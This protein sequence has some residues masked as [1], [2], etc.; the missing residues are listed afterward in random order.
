MDK[1]QKLPPESEKTSADDK[2]LQRF[3]GTINSFVESHDDIQQILQASQSWAD[4]EVERLEKAKTWAYRIAGGAVLF[5]CGALWVAHEAIQTAMVPPPPP[6]VLVMNETTGAINPLMSLTEVKVKYEDALLRRALNTFSICRER[7]IRDMAE[8]D[9]FCAASFMSPQLQSQW[10]KYW[11]TENPNGPLTVYGNRASVKVQIESISPRQNSQGIVDTAQ[12][13]FTRTVT[14]NGTPT[15]T[16]WVADVS[17][18][19]VN[20][21]KEEAQRRVNDIGLQITQYNTNQVLSAASP[22]ARNQAPAPVTAA[23]RQGLTAP[24]YSPNQ[25][26]D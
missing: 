15:V 14:E 19:M 12:I 1:R 13:Y 11:D 6:Q 18:K 7:Y 9:Y 26:R 20:L 16:H 3:L 24:A 22:A 8:S 23:P 10:A 5:A 2:A 21:P 4:T 25:G 17:F